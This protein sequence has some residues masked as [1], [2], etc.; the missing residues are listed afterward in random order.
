MSYWA[1]RR[2]EIPPY[3]DAWMRGARYG[4]ATSVAANGLA[5]VRLDKG[6]Y[7]H[8]FVDDFAWVEDRTT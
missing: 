7:V 4:T 2:V 6:G 5:R 8:V 3:F 1:G